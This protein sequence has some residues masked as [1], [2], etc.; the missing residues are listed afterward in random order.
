MDLATDIRARIDADAVLQAEINRALLAIADR[1]S[2]GSDLR[3]VRI[4]VRTLEASWAEHITLQDEV[5]FP[6]VLGRHIRGVAPIVGRLR[7]EHA[8][9]CECNSDIGKRLG[10]LLHGRHR[11][12]AELEAALRNAFQRRRDHMHVCDELT[13][14]LPATFSAA[15]TSLYYAWQTGRP[16]PRFPLNLINVNTRRVFRIGGRPH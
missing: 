9:I 14:W 5:V 1:M 3:L 16:T 4:L 2:Q 10:G 12:P 8:H 13:G 11:E 7:S 15:E 6:I